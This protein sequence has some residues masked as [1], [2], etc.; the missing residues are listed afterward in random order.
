M[1]YSAESMML[2]GSVSRK[3]MQQALDLQIGE[4]AKMRAAASRLRRL[5]RK[6]MK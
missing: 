2:V 6:R 1:N 3:I 4:N 5:E